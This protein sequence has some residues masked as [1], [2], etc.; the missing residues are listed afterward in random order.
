MQCL[1][2]LATFDAY[3]EIS[4]FHL[5]VWCRLDS[6]IASVGLPFA[7]KWAWLTT[8]LD[9]LVDD[10]VCSPVPLLA[11]CDFVSGMAS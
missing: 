8:R 3:V 9:W 6:Y 1:L 5:T 7:S 10:G 4:S 2:S 11:I